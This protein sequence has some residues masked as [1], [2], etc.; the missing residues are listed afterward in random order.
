MAFAVPGRI[1]DAIIV[2]RALQTALVPGLFDARRA[3]P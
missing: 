1:T 3:G 2:S